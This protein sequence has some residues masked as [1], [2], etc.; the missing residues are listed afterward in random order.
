MSALELA[1]HVAEGPQ[2]AQ[3]ARADDNEEEEEDVASVL[4]TDD[5]ATDDQAPTRKRRRAH[6]DMSWCPLCEAQRTG[7][8]QQCR[9]CK[10]KDGLLPEL[11]GRHQGPRLD[12]PRCERCT[13]KARRCYRCMGYAKT[14]EQKADE[15]KW[16]EDQ[17][18]AAAAPFVPHTCA[19]RH[20][21]PICVPLKTRQFLHSWCMVCHAVRVRPLPGPDGSTLRASCG[22]CQKRMVWSPPEGTA[23]HGVRVGDIF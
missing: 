23:L 5:Q 9:A 4:A 1:A 6:A 7:T 19:N 8:R 15:K 17:K 13:G 22:E 3:Q 12:K 18:A 2:P 11:K 20:R 21:C 10:R 16:E 14:D